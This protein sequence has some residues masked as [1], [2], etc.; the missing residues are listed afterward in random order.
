ML[1][2]ALAT[3]ASM[4]L[5]IALRGLMIRLFALMA[6]CFLAYLCLAVVI[7]TMELRAA[8][9]V[10]RQ[11]ASASVAPLAA[12]S[13]VRGKRA[14][15][16]GATGSTRSTRSTRSTAS[17][18][19]EASSDPGPDEVP[20]PILE[21][22]VEGGV[23]VDEFLDEFESFGT[24]I[25][26]EGFYEPIPELAVKPLTLDSSLLQPPEETLAGEEEAEATAASLD[27]DPGP[28]PDEPE[29][30]EPTFTTP[31]PPKRVWASKR[32]K[33]RPIYI[34][35]QLDDE[36]RPVKAVND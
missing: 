34:E 35:A 28:A 10:R 25:F 19:I 5:A 24:G 14:V 6:V 13:A 12:S 8:E 36:G 30:I 16:T 3:F 18:P 11:R 17:G 15:T 29:R 21:R 2:F 20:G 33:A 27:T 23:E 9:A 31:P 22:E 1:G 32:N 26:D 7:G 4:L